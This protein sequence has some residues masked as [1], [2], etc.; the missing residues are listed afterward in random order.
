MTLRTPELRAAHELLKAHRRETKQPR[1]KP[2]AEKHKNADTRVK[3]PAYLAWLR[4]QPCAVGPD[5][6]SGPVEAAHVRT[7]KRGDPPTGLGRKPDDCRAT[8]LCR[9]H[10]RDGP[11][12]QHKFN[13]LRWWV[14]HGFDPHVVAEEHYARFLADG[15]LEAP[16]VNQIQGLR[17]NK[18]NP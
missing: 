18:E 6:C 5:G 17:R 1:A 16:G 11:D 3:E 13:E 10:H 12:A 14:G 2:K 4:R 9:G 7:A 8:P 15:A